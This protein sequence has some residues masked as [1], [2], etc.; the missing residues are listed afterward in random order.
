VPPLKV[1]VWAGISKRGETSIVIFTGIMTT[2]T[3][4]NSEILQQSLVPF[5]LSTYPDSHWLYQDSDPKHNSRY[6]QRFFKENG[7][8]WWKSHAKSPDIT[9]KMSG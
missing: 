1:H 6:I 4:C 8:N 2:T 5:I 7:M 9:W 3:Y